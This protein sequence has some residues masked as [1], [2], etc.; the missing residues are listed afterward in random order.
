VRGSSP[1]NQSITETL[2]L[3][4]PRN[5]V[6]TALR[7]PALIA[8]CV[9]GA[10]LTSIDADQLVGELTTSLGPI[11]AQFSG[12]ARVIY[13][14]DHTG[15][16]EGEGQDTIS[17]THLHGTAAFALRETTPTSSELTLTL[18]YALRGPLAQLG[19]G[20]VVRAFAAELAETVARALEARLR[21]AEP[22]VPH[23]LGL[24]SLFWRTLRR[25][26]RGH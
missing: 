9:P 16:L 2:N 1:P 7:D 25:W 12:A 23:R 5:T 18:T 10:R 24:L 6:W 19:R 26:L 20:P 3:N 21:G 11:R 13:N 14:D 17:R 15:T 8:S 4:L 22:P